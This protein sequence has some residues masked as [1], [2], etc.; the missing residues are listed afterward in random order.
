MCSLPL[1]AIC[2]RE[3]AG[4][5]LHACKHSI[6]HLIKE[7]EGKEE[8]LEFDI[9]WKTLTRLLD[10]KKHDVVQYFKEK[11]LKLRSVMT[12]DKIWLCQ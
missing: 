3:Y 6:E 5:L 10:L 1:P 12:K 2:S 4:S 7:E 9:F 11:S 8:R